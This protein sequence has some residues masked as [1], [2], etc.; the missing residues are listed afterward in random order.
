VAQDRSIFELFQRAKD[1]ESRNQYEEAIAAYKLI[2]Q[3]KPNHY[4]SLLSLGI[5]YSKLGD[6]ESSSRYYDLA[7]E[8]QRQFQ[9]DREKF[10]VTISASEEKELEDLNVDQILTELIDEVKKEKESQADIDLDDL[11]QS[12][13]GSS[14]EMTNKPVIVRPASMPSP[15]KKP[16]EDINVLLDRASQLIGQRKYDDALQIYKTVIHR[17]PQ[18]EQ[19]WFQSAL[20][21]K[22]QK[23][24]HKT[25]IYF[26][27]VLELNSKNALA[28]DYISWAFLNLK[29]FD[30]TVEHAKMSLELNS[31]NFQAWV[32]LGDAYFELEQYRY[33]LYCYQQAITISPD[34]EIERQVASLVEQDVKPHDPRDEHFKICPKCNE[35]IRQIAKFCDQC[36]ISLLERT[37]DVIKTCII[38][39]E[40]IVSERPTICM[41]CNSPFHRSC[42]LKWIQNY[43][44]CP[45]CNQNPGWI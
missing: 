27:K 3:I 4:F 16:K 15:V 10:Q 20:I 17:D 6:L 28:L 31:E 37:Q 23:K 26:Q 22:E 12:V 32:N 14:P 21:Y 41:S 11:L 2:L 24:Y 18:N 25:A 35:K 30:K 7:D 13:K 8:V 44:V 34:P 36:G 33:A 19:A 42:L 45:H 1:F 9:E 39:R 38:C 29:R 43:Q 40:N 5:N